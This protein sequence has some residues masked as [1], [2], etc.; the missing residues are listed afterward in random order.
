MPEKQE[1]WRVGIGDG[2]REGTAEQSSRCRKLERQRRKGLKRFRSRADRRDC[3]ARRGDRARAIGKNRAGRM[4]STAALLV[5]VAAEGRGTRRH[6]ADAE[7]KQNAERPDQH[8]VI[9]AYAPLSAGE[10]E[11]MNRMA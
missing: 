10:S 9:V 1:A 11:G 5:R 6:R 8:A 7:E 4:L 3:L 2:T